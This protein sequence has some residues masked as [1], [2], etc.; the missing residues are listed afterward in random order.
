ML[1]PGTSV[2]GY[3]IE[4]VL[5][6]GGMGAVYLARHPELPR[7]DALKVLSASGG[8]SDQQFRRRFLREAEV[9][10]TLDHPNIVTVHNRGRASVPTG[11]SAAGRDL[12]W[13][14]MQY[15]P[16]TDAAREVAAKGRLDPRRVS[17]IVTEIAHGLDYAHRRNLLHR[18]IKPA[19]I[20][21]ST[22]EPE[23]DADEQRVVLADFGVAKITD[24]VEGLTSVGTVLATLSYASPDQLSGETLDGTTDQ[25]SLAATAF[26]LL[27]GKVPF[28]D[29]DTGA[30]IAAHLKS[31][32]PRVSDA[33]SGVSPAVDAVIAKAM[34]KSPGARFGTCREFADALAVAVRPRPARPAPRPPHPAPRQHEPRFP[35]PA[36]HGPRRPGAP[37]IPG[38]PRVG[39][40]PR[41][42]PP[43]AGPRPGDGSR[44]RD[45]PRSGDPRR[46]ELTAWQQTQV[47]PNAVPSDPV[48]RRQ[49]DDHVSAPPRDPVRP[50][51]SA[52]NPS[53][54]NPSAPNPSG[55]LHAGP[56]R[57]GAPPTIPGASSGPLDRRPAVPPPP[58]APQAPP[59][60]GPDPGV[61][62]A[63]VAVVLLI[64]VTAIVL[65]VV[66]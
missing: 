63:I 57:G 20:L 40:P 62:I 21:L 7:S 18:D 6:S 66:L 58:R 38:P 26:H 13:I 22:S 35:Q 17:H 12:L 31:P 8:A 10:A 55:P 4:R 48:R 28:D 33:T 27:V 54:P 51:P 11:D 32:V 2:A 36:A 43:P 64:L 37:G 59:S 41:R 45:A 9:A 60:T 61:I 34:A 29:R 14:A 23:D 42:Q 47:S 3:R 39:P 52:P 16:G 30:V 46:G 15:V 49:T 5:G 65:G 24:D 56:N 50:P 19:N 44:H 1:E 25:Y 53:A